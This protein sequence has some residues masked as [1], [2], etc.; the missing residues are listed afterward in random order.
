MKISLFQITSSATSGP[1]LMK[2]CSLLT[3]MT[4][5]PSSAEETTFTASSSSVFLKIM[6]GTH[7]KST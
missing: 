7:I 2:F 3:Y 4:V 6:Y 5:F 1:L